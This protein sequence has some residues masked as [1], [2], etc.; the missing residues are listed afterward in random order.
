MPRRQWCRRA[1]SVGGVLVVLSLMAALSR[2]SSTEAAWVDGEHGRTTFTAGLLNT[3][4]GNGCATS[5]GAL[6]PAWK[7]A[8][9]PSVGNPSF[10]YRLSW[11]SWLSSGTVFDWTSPSKATSFSH[12]PSLGL[13]ETRTYRFEVRAVIGSWVTAPRAGSVTVSWGLLG[14]IFGACTWQ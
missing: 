1:W 5:G 14:N 6:A 10:Q 12:T 11:S 13:L 2:T 4:V 9:P 8:P 7:A 3:P